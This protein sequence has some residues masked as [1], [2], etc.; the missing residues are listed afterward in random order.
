[1]VKMEIA[2]IPCLNSKIKCSLFLL[3]I[4]SLILMRFIATILDKKPNMDIII[5]H[6]IAN[7]R[8]N[9]LIMSA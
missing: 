2:I 1:M 8:E 6:L 5:F 4:T 9:D 3:S 7:L